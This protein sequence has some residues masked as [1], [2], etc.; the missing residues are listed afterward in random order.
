MHEKRRR[1]TQENRDR[2]HRRD[3]II[4]D[5]ETIKVAAMTGNLIYY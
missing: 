1:V 4:P 3:E 2:Q 5:G